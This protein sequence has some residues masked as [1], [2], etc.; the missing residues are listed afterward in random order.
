MKRSGLR[1]PHRLRRLLFIYIVY[2]IIF[3]ALIYMIPVH[4]KEL[5]ETAGYYSRTYGPDRAVLVERPQDAFARR[6][7]IM[8]SAEKTLDVCYHCVKAGDTTECMFAEMLR[9]ADRGV[10]VRVMLDGAIGGLTGEHENIDIALRSHPNVEFRAYNPVNL[11]K[12]WGWNARLHDKFI[13]ADDRMMML[14]GRNIGDEY[15]APPGYDGNVTYDRDVIVI[16][17]EAGKGKES[18]SVI[19][20]VSDYMDVLWNAKETKAFGKLT[21]RGRKKGLEEQE[22][23]KKTASAMERSF[24]AYY[25]PESPAEDISVPS[26]KI[27]LLHNPVTPFKKEPVTGAVIA[28][29]LSEHKDIRI[30][31]P[32]ATVNRSTLKALKNIADGSNVD[33]LT[34]SMTSTPNLPAFSTYVTQRRKF[35]D[36]GINIYEYQS[37]DS[38]HGKTYTAD[39]HLSIV[40]SL[41]LD[42][43]SLYIDTESVLVIDS[44][45]F[46]SILDGELDR[47]F[48]RSAR[49]GQDN[50]YEETQGV[51][52]VEVTPLK[53]A[54]VYVTSVFS[55]LFEYLV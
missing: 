50:E 28:E 46:C 10:K 27:S 5:P 17:T 29:L 31:T 43:R 37:T 7:E 41:N 12:P 26:G 23:I 45:E 54:L 22:R 55:R 53:K 16:N 30:Q 49:V 8:R 24:P 2:I 13:V 48:E 32:Y 34:N 51:D 39:G 44:P 1:L 20:E 15:F 35:M 36:T 19:Y 18:G 40:G 21:E 14:G 47:L 6:I 3:G 33:F 38:I 25:E 4:V 11:L 52:I 9:A 42:D